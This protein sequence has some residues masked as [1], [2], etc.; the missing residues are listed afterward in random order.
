[1][2]TIERL[3]WLGGAALLVLWLAVLPAAAQQQYAGVKGEVIGLNNKPLPNAQ[4]T[5]TPSNGK[6]PVKFKAN[7]KGQFESRYV[8]GGT[9]NMSVMSSMG[10]SIDVH[11]GMALEAGKMYNVPVNLAVIAAAE[12]GGPPPKGM[13][14]EEA[15]AYKARKTKAEAKNAKFGKLN[16]LLAQ[17]KQLVD[18]KQ[19]TQAIAVMQQAVAIDQTHDII[20]AN[21]AADYAGAK[22]YKQAADAYAKA[23]AL[24]PTDAGYEINMGS[25]LA[26]AGDTAGAAAAY[27]KAAQMDPTAAKMAI[28]NEGVVLMNKGDLKGASAAFD[29]VTKL[30]PSDAD[31]WYEDAMSLLGQAG[32]DPKTNKM[33]PVPGTKEALQKVIQLAPNTQNAATAKAALQQLGGGE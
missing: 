6:N 30:D 5:L 23:I 26:E 8:P 11:D 7:K 18:A 1:M 17:N 14:A 3:G 33:L 16:T 28:Y 10:Q 15:A 24:K 32:T 22:Q 13:S 12:S 29:K 25:A 2:K 21:L 4:I 20:Y 31:A 9:Y 19:Y 27:N